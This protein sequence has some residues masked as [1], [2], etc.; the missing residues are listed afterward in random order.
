MNNRS[1]DGNG[2]TSGSAP[3]EETWLLGQPS[4]WEYLEFVRESVV[5]GA[6]IDPAKATA[7]WRTANAYYEELEESESGIADRAE[8]R[9]LDGNLSSLAAEVAA[10]PSFRKVFDTMPTEFGMVELDKLVLYQ[11]S[12]TSTFVDTL[13]ARLGPN[14]SPDAL[15][16]FC[17]PLDKPDIP[18]QAHAMGSNRFVFRTA[19]TDFRFHQPVLLRPDQVSN[20]VS[21]GPVS[22]VVGLVVGFGSNLLNVIKVDNRL[23]LH[24][25]YH[26]A[27]ALRALGVT[28]A[29]CIIQPVAT[30]DE[31]EVTA[32]STVSRNPDF[33]FKSARPPVLKDYF[34]P[35]IRKVLPVHKHVRII[36]VNFEV[37]EYLVPE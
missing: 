33:Y 13:K 35:K 10:H 15:F 19:S 8:C 30:R 37:K 12:V 27:C 7:E 14:P 23:L 31:L 5:D 1:R 6:D 34:D 22:G 9:A 18:V 17:M 29:P 20:Y 32:K 16:R 26:R 11:K 36:E 25:G 3:H 24:N 21:I 28:H 2:S 4:L